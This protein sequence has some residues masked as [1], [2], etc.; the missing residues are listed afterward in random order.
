MR[1]FAITSFVWLITVKLA[2]MSLDTFVLSSLNKSLGSPPCFCFWRRFIFCPSVLPLAA[3]MIKQAIIIRTDIGMGKGKMVTQGCHAS[4]KSA[5]SCI[6]NDAWA[7]WFTEWDSDGFYKKIV[8]KVTS[9]KEINNIASA[10]RADFL[11]VFIV[12]DK[13]LTQ[14][15]PDTITAIAIGPAPEE[16]IDV[17]TSKLK[18]L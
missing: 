13:G 5:L 17:I 14:I 6:G 8:L 3:V 4:L 7:G 15:E 16:R 10:A 11:P 1:P 18:L 9:E 2:I 12:R